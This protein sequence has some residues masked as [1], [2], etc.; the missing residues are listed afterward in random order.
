[1]ATL[2]QQ[3]EGVVGLPRPAPAHVVVREPQV[4]DGLHVLDVDQ[5]AQVAAADRLPDP[6]VGLEMAE[7]VAD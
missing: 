2:V 3:Q 6:A 7:R 5:P 1:M 4:A